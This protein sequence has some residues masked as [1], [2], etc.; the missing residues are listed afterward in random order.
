MMALRLC[1]KEEEESQVM[2]WY[3]NDGRCATYI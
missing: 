3:D 1:M 2:V